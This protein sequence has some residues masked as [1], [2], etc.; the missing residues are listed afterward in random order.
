MFQRKLKNERR[1]S[2]KIFKTFCQKKFQFWLQPETSLEKKLLLAKY[3][4]GKL[5]GWKKSPQIVQ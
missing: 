1:R 3:Y 4:V 5:D 2:D